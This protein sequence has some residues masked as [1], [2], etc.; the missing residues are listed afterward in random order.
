MF[1]A[2]SLAALAAKTGDQMLAVA[3][4]LTKSDVDRMAGSDLVLAAKRVGTAAAAH[5]PVLASDYGVT[6]ADLTELTTLTTGYD[7][8]KTAPRDA[9]VD[10]KVVTLALPEAITYVRGI[11]RNELDKLMTRFKRPQRDF[12]AAYTAARI[13]IDLPG[14]HPKKPAAPPTP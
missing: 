7:Q 4:N 6:A 9:T 13:I 14:T 11:Y 3:V 5:A 2:D 1:V 10:R 12:F 8:L